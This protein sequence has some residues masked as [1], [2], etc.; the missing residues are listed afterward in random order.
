MP[1]DGYMFPFKITAGAVNFRTRGA[2][3]ERIETLPQGN[4][5][6][7]EHEQDR[8]REAVNKT[9]FVDLFLM[10][11]ELPSQQRTAT[12]VTERVNERMLILS[13]ILGRISGEMLDP[14]VKRLYNIGTRRGILPPVPD[15]LRGQEYKVTYISPLAKAQ[16]L[17]EMQSLTAFFNAVLAMSELLP[18]MRD[19]IDPDR[20]INEMADIYNMTGTV[21]RD[22]SEVNQ[23][24]SERAKMQQEAVQAQQ[25]EQ[26]ANVADK[27]ASAIQKVGGVE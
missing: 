11:S 6:I 21:M 13:P 27:G 24:R 16:R 18:E 2:N 26:M 15:V 8:R 4:I 22:D 25:M 12:E 19:K 7:G 17:A 5:Q 10:L 1:D 20:T 14:L 9:F 23:I 3:G